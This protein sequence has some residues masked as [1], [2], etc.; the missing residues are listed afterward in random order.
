MK[1]N[2]RYGET[3]LRMGS[4]SDSNTPQIV[5]W[6]GL[7]GHSIGLV[8]RVWKSAAQFSAILS[9]G[10]TIDKSACLVIS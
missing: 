9:S 5:N 4:P 2:A 8:A 6:L 3:D 1:V 7:L 10:L